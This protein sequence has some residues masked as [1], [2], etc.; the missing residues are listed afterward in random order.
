MKHYGNPLLSRRSLLAAAPLAL[1]GMG[2]ASPASA[3]G[4]LEPERLG[5]GA[6]QYRANRYWGLLDRQRYPVADCRQRGQ[7]GLAEVQGVGGR[8]GRDQDRR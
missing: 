5:Q 7:D 6:F 4:Q 2:A 1:A 8:G 3:S